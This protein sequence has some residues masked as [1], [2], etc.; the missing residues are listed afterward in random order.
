MFNRQPRENLPSGN[1]VRLLGAIG[2]D[3]SKI[4]LGKTTSC[5]AQKQIDF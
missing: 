5:K 4:V 3:S 1:D 2:N